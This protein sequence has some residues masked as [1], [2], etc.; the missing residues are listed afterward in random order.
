LNISKIIIVN[1]M[2]LMLGKEGTVVRIYKTRV[3]SFDAVEM[4]NGRTRKVWSTKTDKVV[5]FPVYELGFIE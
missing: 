5:E 2:H 4:P 3:S 1:N